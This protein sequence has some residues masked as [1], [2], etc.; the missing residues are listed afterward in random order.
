MSATETE[1]HFFIER[2]R[3]AM[4]IREIDP[5]MHPRHVAN[6]GTMNRSDAWET[7][8]L[9]AMPAKRSQNPASRVAVPLVFQAIDGMRTVVMTAQAVQTAWEALQTSSLDDVMTSMDR[10]GLPSAGAA[11]KSWKDS[12]PRNLEAYERLHTLN[13]NGRLTGFTASLFEGLCKYGKLTD[14]QRDALLSSDDKP[15]DV[16]KHDVPAGHYAIEIDDTIK[17]YKVDRPTEGRWTGYTFV[18]VQ[19]SDD[20]FP[21]RDKASRETIL[22]IIARDP[23]SASKRYG[24]AIGKCGICNR[25]LTDSTSIANGIGPVCA[26]KVGW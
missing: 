24:H 13:N 21:I 20:Y 12:D 7:A 2:Q 17:F 4:I 5:V 3:D 26:S 15:K 16:V 8:K 19:A 9:R 22:S 25:T 18:K 14:R 23:Q 1:R 11:S 6:G 10:Q